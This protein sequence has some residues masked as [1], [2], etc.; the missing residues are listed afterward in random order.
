MLR[1]LQQE[2][3][4]ALYEEEAESAACASVLERIS[5]LPELPAKQ[6]LDLYRGSVAQVVHDALGEIFPVCAELVGDDCFRSVSNR[7]MRAAPSRHADLARLG[8]G[9]PDFVAE[10]SFLSSVSYLADMGRLELGLHHAHAAP[11]PEP[12]VDPAKLSEAISSEPEAWRFIL[13]P[14]ATLLGS[15]HP[16]LSIWEAHQDRRVERGWKLDPTAPG[17][18]M[19]ICRHGTEIYADFVEPSLW[20]ILQSIAAGEAVDQQLA[21]A[22][23]LRRT[24]SPDSSLAV[25]SED[26]VPILTTI[27]ALF[28]R[29][30]VVGGR[31]L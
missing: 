12:S 3:A 23:G 5:P 15:P 6:C 28:E 9:W 8:D 26:S 17:E 18:Q 2:L 4:R 30:W 20:P 22:D 7:Y 13:P 19:I 11:W 24:P 16:V 29:G 1:E 21:L 25:D 27:Q 14:S 31:P 10:Q